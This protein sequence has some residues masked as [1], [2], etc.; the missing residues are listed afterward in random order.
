MKRSIDTTTAAFARPASFDIEGVGVPWDTGAVGL[1][2]RELFAAMAMQSLVATYRP[3]RPTMRLADVDDAE[4][5]RAHAERI[6]AVAVYCAD[7]LLDAL[8]AMP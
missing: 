1:T 8:E 3:R 7:A 2:K 5:D 6:A 4:Q